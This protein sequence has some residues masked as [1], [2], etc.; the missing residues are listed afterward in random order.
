LARNHREEKPPYVPLR[1]RPLR[2]WMEDF[3]G[4]G[5][6]IS[7]LERWREEVADISAADVAL[8]APHTDR[9]RR[10]TP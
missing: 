3:L 6:N 5:F 8:I 10:W 1:Q 4:D 7:R 2:W 9:N